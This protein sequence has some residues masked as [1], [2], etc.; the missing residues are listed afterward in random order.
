VFPVE[1]WSYYPLTMLVR[2]TALWIIWQQVRLRTGDASAGANFYFWALKFDVNT[3][4]TPLWAAATFFLLRSYR[5]RGTG[6]AALAGPAV[7]ACVLAKYWSLVLLATFAV[8]A[9]I[10]SRRAGYFRSAA[11]WISAAVVLI[12]ISPHLVWLVQNDYAPINY[13]VE[14]HARKRFADAAPGAIR[15]FA[16]FIGYVLVPL[17]IM[18]TLRPG[19][20]VVLDLVW[21]Q[22]R[23]R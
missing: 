21:P 22:D 7:G 17:L 12:V 3:M 18:V 23:E 1:E 9:A 11:P 10:A 16:G 19:I 20:A 6:V 14:E 4:L 8:A 15:Y 13:A 2:V 5:T